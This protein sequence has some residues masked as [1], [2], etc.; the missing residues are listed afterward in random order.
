MAAAKSWR[1]FMRNAEEI[2]QEAASFPVEERVIVVESLL[3]F[4]RKQKLIIHL[5]A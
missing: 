4:I 5:Q 2:I 3:V 1:C